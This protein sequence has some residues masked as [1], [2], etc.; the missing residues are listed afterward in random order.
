[1]SGW[2]TTFMNCRL[3]INGKLIEDQLVVSD[4]VCTNSFSLGS[5][6]ALTREDGRPAKSLK[7]QDI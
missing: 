4:E 1:M 2:F 3:C 7:G 6:G 5:Y